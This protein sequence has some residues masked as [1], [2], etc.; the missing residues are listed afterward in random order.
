MH[1]NRIK[2]KD[3]KNQTLLRKFRNED[4]FNKDKGSSSKDLIHMK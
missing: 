3:I 4:S 2:V 1:K